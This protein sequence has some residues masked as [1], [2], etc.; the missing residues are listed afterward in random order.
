MD[1]IFI[2]IVVLLIPLTMIGIGVLF[3]KRVPAKINFVCGYRTRMSMK[4]KD[5]WV[6]A[7]RHCGKTWQNIG[8][9]MLPCSVCAMIFVL[10]QDVVDV[11]IF[12]CI[13]VLVQMI[14]LIGSIIPTELALKKTFDDQGNRKN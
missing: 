11:N 5:T 2:L 10:G 1:W 4:N 7:H 8:L 13:L 9:I 3:A 6:F 14:F 12:G